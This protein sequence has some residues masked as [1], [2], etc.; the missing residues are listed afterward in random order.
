M[1]GMSMAVQANRFDDLLPIAICKSATLNELYK[2]SEL[3][4]YLLGFYFL[5]HKS[6][7]LCI[8]TGSSAT[9]KHVQVEMDRRSNSRSNTTEI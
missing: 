6:V 8:L 9:S 4:N 7:Y 1:I 5:K 2:L 3:N